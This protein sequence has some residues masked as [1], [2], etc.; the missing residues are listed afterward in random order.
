VTQITPDT[1]F[2]SAEDDNL[3]EDVALTEYDIIATANDFNVRTLYDFIRSG[4]VKIPAF[5]RNFVWDIKRASK[6]IESLLLGLP[7]P[8]VFLYEEDRNRFLVIDGQQRMM[9]L[10]YFMKGRFP[11]PEIRGMLRDIFNEKSDIPDSILDDDSLFRDFSLQLPTRES[12]ELNS[13]HGRKF[14]T[15]NELQGVLEM[16][17]IRNIIIKQTKPENDDS[18]IYEIFNRLNSGGVTLKPQEIRTALYH[19]PFY[20]SLAKLN[21]LKDWRTVLDL[22]MTDVHLRDMEY[23]VR[24]YAMLV[25]GDSYAPSLVKFINKFSKTAKS[26]NAGRIDLLSE[27]GKAFFSKAAAMKPHAFFNRKTNRFNVPL[28]EAAFVGACHRALRD[29]NPALVNISDAVMD[30][31]HADTEFLAATQM[32]TTGSAKV[33]TRLRRAIDIVSRGVN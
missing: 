28:F 30:A 7:I 22:P 21:Q 9:S 27:I 24:C 6:L 29:S 13:L 17:T 10:Y 32:H 26:F 11:K 3:G 14:S 25:S 18:S 5:Q 2:E 4:A 12:G 16:K 33:Q 23:L 8:Q 15:L 1:F 19:S 20:V 31:L